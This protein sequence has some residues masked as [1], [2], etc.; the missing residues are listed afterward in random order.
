MNESIKKK[1]NNKKFYPKNIFAGNDW[2]GNLKFYIR[3]L[4]EMQ[5]LD[6]FTVSETFE[7]RSSI[8]KGNQLT[9]IENAELNVFVMI[10]MIKMNK[11]MIF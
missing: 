4:C 7:L 6:F 2:E 10:K 1:I 11:K 8:K 3:Y 9:K 5:Y